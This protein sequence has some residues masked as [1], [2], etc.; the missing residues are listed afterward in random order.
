MERDN[1]A[2]LRYCKCRGSSKKLNTVILLALRFL[3][4]Q[5]VRT[6]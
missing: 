4:R 2:S 6:A 5:N 3:L 1:Y